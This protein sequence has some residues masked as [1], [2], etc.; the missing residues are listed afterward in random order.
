MRIEVFLDDQPDPIH[1]LTPPEKF[2]LDTESIQDGDHSLTFKA[3]DDDGDVSQR[4]VPFTVQNGPEIAIHGIVEGDVLTGDVSILA[5]A[6]GSKIGDVFEPVRMETPTPIPTWA[7]VLVLCVLAWGVGYI[8]LEL[9]DRI[10]TVV[11]HKDADPASGQSAAA[12]DDSALGDQVYGINC[13]SCH[14]ADGS[15]LS[16]VFPPL[17]DNAVVLADDPTEHI[18]AVLNGVVGKTIDGVVYA[19]PM[20]P[21]GALLSDEE[22]A[23]VVNHERTQWGNSAPLVSPADVEALR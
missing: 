17:V 20:P 13:A 11:V 2:S 18:V 1:I 7:W 23:A 15:G 8:S 16:G 19:S 14:Q 6:Y 9:H 5:N 3:I 12:A 22:V 10:D 21:F 4:S